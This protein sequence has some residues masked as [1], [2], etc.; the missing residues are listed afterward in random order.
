VSIGY[1]PNSDCYGSDEVLARIFIGNPAEAETCRAEL[2][3]L[4]QEAQGD[5]LRCLFQRLVELL[6][7]KLHAHHG[8]LAWPDSGSPMT[9]AEIAQL[10]PWDQ[11]T[12]ADDL[13][14]LAKVGLLER[15]DVRTWPS[16]EAA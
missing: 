2:A 5:R 6:Q 7:G 1:V 3:S 16:M 12:I 13:R 4:G 14:Q 10:V 15:I 8:L 9:A 11:S